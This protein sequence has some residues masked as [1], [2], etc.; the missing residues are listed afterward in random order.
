MSTETLRRV[1]RHWFTTQNNQDFD[2]VRGVGIFA[3]VADTVFQAMTLESFNPINYMG[4]VATVLTIIAGADKLRETPLN[5]PTA[6]VEGPTTVVNT[7]KTTI[8]P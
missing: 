7:G 6:T 4:S 3:I 2:P 5:R 1:L 8:R